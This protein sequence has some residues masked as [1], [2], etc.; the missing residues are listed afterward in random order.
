MPLLRPLRD[1]D[2][3]NVINMFTFT[4]QPWGLTGI[5]NKGT[6]VAVASNGGWRNDNQP[7]NILGSYGD[8]SVNNVQALRYGTSAAV[9]FYG[10]GTAGIMTGQ[11]GVGGGV[12]PSVFSGEYPIGLTLFDIRELDENTIPLK[13]NSRKAAELEACISGQTVP[14]VTRGTFLYSGLTGTFG[15]GAALYAGASGTLSAYSGTPLLGMGN[16]SYPSSQ[17]QVGI[18]LGGTGV[19]G[20][21]LIRLGLY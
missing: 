18:T 4:G 7:L 14:I 3:K 13:Y 9:T 17:V 8:F 1:Y 12:V 20:S 11:T 5:V 21:A 19:D 2:E 10:T 15:G 6:L 16:T